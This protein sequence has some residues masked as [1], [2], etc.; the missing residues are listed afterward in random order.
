MNKDEFAYPGKPLGIAEEAINGKGTYECNGEIFSSVFGRVV[1]EHGEISVIPKKGISNIS[2][3]QVVY[4]VVVDVMDSLALISI[5]SISR[6]MERIVPA[7]DYGVLRVMNIRDG[8]VPS[9]KNE[10]KRGDI[11]KAIVDDTSTGIALNTKG[12]EFGVIKAYCTSC[13]GAMDA[14]GRILK[15][16]K[17]GRTDSKRK[18]SKNYSTDI[19]INEIKERR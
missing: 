15:C 1:R 13:R 3:G 9:A 16:E 6:G 4:G 10:M 12:F 2:K 7:Q 8:F 5:I 18:L 19:A 17:C 11:V 14:S